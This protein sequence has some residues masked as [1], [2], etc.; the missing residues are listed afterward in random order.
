MRV[1]YSA[2]VL[3]PKS[4]IDVLHAVRGIPHAGWDCKAHHMTICFG[5]GLPEHLKRDLGKRVPLTV[6]HIGKYSN[7]AIAVRVAG[8]ESQNKNAHVTCWV[9]TRAGGKSVDSNKIEFWKPVKNFT[10][11]GTVE[12]VKG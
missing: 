6:T 1:L 2:V 12:E 7:S 11:H 8:Y 9:N 5:C 4:K 10:I 3:D